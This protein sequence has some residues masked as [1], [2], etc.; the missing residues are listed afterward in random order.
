MVK[1]HSYGLPDVDVHFEE[2]LY[3]KISES[4]SSNNLGWE[5][6]KLKVS[7]CAKQGG[8]YILFLHK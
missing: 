8:C 3:L 1:P 5:Y 4:W 6:M 2:H 7:Y